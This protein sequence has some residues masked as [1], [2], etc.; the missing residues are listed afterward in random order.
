M[1]IDI[2]FYSQDWNLDDWENLGYKSKEEAA[3]WQESCCGILCMKMILDRFQLRKNEDLL[4][5]VKELID[6]G[7]K[8][9]AYHAIT[10]WSRSG[11]AAFIKS[12]N[13][14]AEAKNLS[15]HDIKEAL[16]R[17]QFVIAS[18]KWGFQGHRN[19]KERIQFWRKHGG[20]LIVVLGYEERKGDL[21]GFYV[22]HTSEIEEIEWPDAFI[23]L[24][25]F[26]KNFARRGIVVGEEV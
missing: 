16:D 17:G 13:Y 21:T 24:A 15:V 26:S 4:P 19:L 7:V 2:P 22:H 6:Q 8:R 10:G 9:G 12:F 1:K 25:K 5:P 18:V 23:P 11:L 3:Y 20:H 14:H